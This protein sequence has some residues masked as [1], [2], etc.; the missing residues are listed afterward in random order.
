[1]FQRYGASAKSLRIL[2]NTDHKESRSIADN[3][4]GKAFLDTFLQQANKNPEEEKQ[5]DLS[6]S[7]KLVIN[8]ETYLKPEEIVELL[9]FKPEEMEDEEEQEENPFQDKEQGGDPKYE[10]SG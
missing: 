4:A 5:A 6:Q 8:R 9:Q 1:M 7:Q 3:L 2:E 10:F